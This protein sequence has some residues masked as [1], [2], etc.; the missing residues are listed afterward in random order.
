[1]KLAILLVSVFSAGFLATLSCT[2]PQYVGGLC[3]ETPDCHTDDNKQPDGSVCDK[4]G[5]CTCPEGTMPCCPNGFPGACVANCSAENAALCAGGSPH[6]AGSDGGGH[7]TVDSDCPQPPSKMCGA[8]VC[9]NGTCE[10]LI[11]VGPID[12]QKWGDCRRRE[13]DA[14]GEVIE[15]G[16]DA[17][18]YD[19]V[20]PCT[21]DFCQGESVNF[22]LENGTPCSQSG[23][24]DGYCYDK[25]CVECIGSML[26]AGCTANGMTCDFFSCVPF[27]QCSGGSCGGACAPCGAGSGC[28][29]PDDC[30]SGVCAG[31]LCK[32]AQC[33]D[34]VK[35]GE[36]TGIDCG[37]PACPPCSDGLSCSSPNDC[38]SD[39]CLYG[40]CAAPTCKDGTQNGGEAGV[41]CGGPC[42]PC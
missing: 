14:T 2:S 15:I 31:G 39:V 22:K 42:G 17:D 30:I 3:G 8:G 16:D 25:R 13:C 7:C 21:I 34:T 29:I 33:D 18:Y 41:D 6:D 12:S 9:T 27:A 4:N 28:G 40:T 36:E 26:G 11:K 1:M 38:Q 35:N 32:V 24:G 20:N 5:V 23:I 37:G 10:M 19:D